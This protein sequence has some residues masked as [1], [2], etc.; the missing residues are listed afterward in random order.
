MARAIVFRP[1]LEDTAL[2]PGS[3]WSTA[4]VGGNYEW[5]K[6]DGKGGRY[7]DARTRFFYQATVNTPA[8]VA[9]MVGKGSQYAVATTDKEGE[10]LDGSRTY[11]LTVPANAPAKDSGRWRST[12]PRP[13]PSFRPDS[14]S[15]ARTTNAMRWAKTPTA[16]STSISG[17]RRPRARK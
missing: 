3:A 12:T 2:Y 8:M 6:D 9:K 10:Y 13:D 4:F 17:R 11:K 7:L 5:L 1:R 15:R 14:V 16:L